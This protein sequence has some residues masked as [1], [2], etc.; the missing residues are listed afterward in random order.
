M[1]APWRMLY[2]DPHHA[3][4]LGRTRILS[5]RDE[6]LQGKR[7]CQIA[8]RFSSSL[9]ERWPAVYC[10]PRQVRTRQAQDAARPRIKIGQIG[11][12]HAHATKL[13]VYRHSPDYEV[14]GIVEP[15]PRPAQAGR[16]A[17]KPFAA[18]RG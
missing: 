13:S 9:A 14:V 2:S 8:G 16:G 17:R 3:K 5:A 10:L 11:V 6:G 7:P 4:R 15:D 1:P 12:G 18:C